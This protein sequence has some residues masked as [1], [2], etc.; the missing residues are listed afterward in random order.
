MR[1]KTKYSMPCS[2]PTKYLI[3]WLERQGM[4]EIKYLKENS[5]QCKWHKFI[6]TVTAFDTVNFCASQVKR[7]SL[8]MDYGKGIGCAI[9]CK[10]VYKLSPHRNI[11][12][13]IVIK[14]SELKILHAR[15]AK[16]K[17][18]VNNVDKTL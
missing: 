11:F 12:S 13:V 6:V 9:C 18:M 8:I 10:T 16:Q 2:L 17:I 5:V 1:S 4:L 3:L 14:E 15:L 7:N